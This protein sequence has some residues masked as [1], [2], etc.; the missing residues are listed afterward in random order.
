LSINLSENEFQG[1]GSKV[2]WLDA[3]I[4]RRK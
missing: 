3:K 2:N 4:K 1:H